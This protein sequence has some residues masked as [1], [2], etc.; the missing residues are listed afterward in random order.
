MS[1]VIELE[2][3]EAAV[4]L[5]GDGA[6]ELIVPEQEGDDIVPEDIL[7]LS[8]FMIAFREPEFRQYML[9]LFGESYGDSAH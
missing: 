1:E 8:A 4:V 3:D 5:K 7:V 2:D 9:S 6:L